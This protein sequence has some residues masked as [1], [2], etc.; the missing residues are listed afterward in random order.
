M[1]RLPIIRHIRYWCLSIRFAIW[2]ENLG[3]HLGA[4]PNQADFDY[5][6]DVWAGKA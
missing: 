5:L 1:K 3:R 2:W 4:V 6:D